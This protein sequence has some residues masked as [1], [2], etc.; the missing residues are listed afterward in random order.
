MTEY[1]VKVKAEN[2]ITVVAKNDKGIEKEFD[3][4]VMAYNEIYSQGENEEEAKDKINAMPI[5]EVFEEYAILEECERYLEE[6]YL[7]S[8]KNK[9]YGR[10]YHDVFDEFFITSIEVEDSDK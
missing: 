6:G 8:I 3:I 10:S 2:F 9:I 5:H 1:L 4:E 7:A